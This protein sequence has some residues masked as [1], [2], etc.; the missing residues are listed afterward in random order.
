M[1]MKSITVLFLAVAATV[2]SA[3]HPR[4]FIADDALSVLSIQEGI[5]VNAIIETINEESGSKFADATYLDTFLAALFEDPTAVDLT[6]EFLLAVEPTVLAEGQRP[7]GMFGPMPHL[8]VVC[9]AKEGRTLTPVGSFLK[10]S[11]M[12][13]GWFLASGEDSVST[14]TKKELSPIFSLLQDA[15]ISAVVRL[16]PIWKQFGPIAQMMGGMFIGSMNKPGLDGVIS[17]DQRAQTKVAREAFKIASA[18]CGDVET[19]SVG[20]NIENF[21]LTSI[22]EVEMTE[23]NG[24]KVDNGSLIEMASFLVDSPLQYAV[25]KEMTL[26]LLA[27]QQGSLGQQ[28]GGIPSELL[29]CLQALAE[30]A[31]DNVGGLSMDSSNGLTVSALVDVVNQAA[32]LEGCSEQVT[33]MMDFL[34]DEYNMHLSVS[35]VPYAWD[36]SM[37]ETD[38]LELQAMHAVIH[39][40]AQLRFK[41]QGSGR[42]AMVFGPASWRAFSA[43]HISSLSQVM[44]SHSRNIAIELACSADLRKLIAGFMHVAN[45]ESKKQTLIA[46][47]PSVKSSLLFGSTNTGTFIE[48]KS[49]LMGLAKLVVEMENS[50]Q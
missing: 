45:Q 20:L 29:I 25:S 12:V 49:N 32:Y 38:A 21:E 5:A 19:I 47:S 41:K 34:T 15:Q 2:A 1:K 16:G 18:W 39:K 28:I 24:V 40:G 44:R 3:Q 11:K 26:K 17:K 9:K 31:G 46:S 48:F 10:S 23:A 7:S 22:I 4:D 30:I 27:F 43:P 13:D 6:Q 37:S 8:F 14:Q 42:I 33:T 50:T 35:D 36:V